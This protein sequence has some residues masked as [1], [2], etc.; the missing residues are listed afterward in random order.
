MIFDM[1]TSVQREELQV[2]SLETWHMRREQDKPDYNG[3]KQ[4]KTEIQSSSFS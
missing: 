2:S 1:E 4:F 3:F